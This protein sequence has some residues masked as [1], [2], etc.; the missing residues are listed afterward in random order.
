MKKSF[1]IHTDFTSQ[2]FDKRKKKIDAIVIHST[3]LPFKES[4][5]RLCD[6]YAKVSCHYLIDLNGRIYQLVEDE[7]R[8]WH[9]GISY[10]KRKNS[11]NNNSIGIEL[12]DKD[13]KGINIKNFPSAQMSSLIKLLKVLIKKYKIAK[14]NV[15]AHSDIAPN[16]KDDPGEYF[17][18]QLLASHNV[19]EYHNLDI[20]NEKDLCFLDPQTA[21][22][23]KIKELQRMLKAYGY[24][25]KITGKFDDQT[26]E[27]IAAFRRRFNPKNLKKNYFSSID[28]K[29]L[30]NLKSM[31]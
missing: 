22:I 7:K 17:N 5:E 6:P 3:H 20:K 16:R 27:V 31:L 29:V 9:A 4:L 28:F 18:W 11:L 26:K 19:A 15:L 30:S 24:K 21:T 8:A 12:V 14:N 2:N 1:F 10:W 23:T 13:A 25:I